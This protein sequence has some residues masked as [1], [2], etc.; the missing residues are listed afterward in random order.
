MNSSSARGGF[1]IWR[2]D[3]GHSFAEFAALVATH[4]A[5]AE[6]GVDTG[7]PPF[8]HQVTGPTLEP[9]TTSTWRLM[10]ME[11]TYAIACLA[12]NET[13]RQNG[14]AREF[15]ATYAAGPIHI[16]AS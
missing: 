5:G 15:V 13:G 9:A 7:A 12:P 11:A 14:M 6:Q 1:H 8:A 10:T 3:E 16:S 4:L 2:L